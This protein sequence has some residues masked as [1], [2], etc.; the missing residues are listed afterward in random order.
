MAK[1]V[2]VD[3]LREYQRARGR[4]P[5]LYFASDNAGKLWG[6]EDA[7]T[8]IR[9]FG[10]LKRQDKCDLII[11]TDGGSMSAA[12]R[13]ALAIREI[14]DD[15]HVVVP[16]KAKSAGTIIA[17]SANLIE[18]ALGA[19]IGAIDP[20]IRIAREGASALPDTIASEDIR[21]MVE[22]CRDWFGMNRKTAGPILLQLLGQK[23]FPT[24]LSSIYR[25]QRSIYDT[26]ERLLRFQLPGTTKERRKAIASNLIAGFREHSDPILFVEAREIGLAVNQMDVVTE[27][28]VR[29]L[30]L[31]AKSHCVDFLRLEP[32]EFSPTAIIASPNMIFN[33][34]VDTRN[35]PFAQKGWVQC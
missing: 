8:C 10:D 27:K 25:S 17:I 31:A 24:T 3:L 21:V 34:G 15:F 6:A 7:K 1:S 26:C 9:V 5:V 16:Y 22:M 18:M 13:L 12:K 28:R 11:H 23:I 29:E 14:T 20:I 30:C 32:A 35:S 4:I 19:E 2:I 33:Y